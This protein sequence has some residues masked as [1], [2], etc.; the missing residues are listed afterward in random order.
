VPRRRSKPT[1][2]LLLVAGL[3]GSL[4]HLT[5]RAQAPQATKSASDGVYT[6]AQ[7]ERGQAA[8]ETHCTECHGDNLRGNEGPALVG[9][10]FLQKWEGEGLGRLFE[11]IRDSMPK[12]SV[13]ALS[14]DEKVDVIAYLLQA[15]G[16]PTGSVELPHEGTEL[17][18]IQLPASRSGRPRDGSIVEV[19]GCL[20]HGASSDWLLRN[21]TEPRAIKLDAPKAAAT[22]Q[23][24]NKDVVLLSVFPSPAAHDGHKMQARGLLISNPAGDRINV[25]ALEMLDASCQ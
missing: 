19:V 12:D 6:A 9:N 16:F 18:A 22:V 11:K 2:L 5:A 20:A 15:N 21:A 14:T 13:S 23:L 1:F 24:G 3:S 4:S 7:A 17:A 10:S 25:L 8:V